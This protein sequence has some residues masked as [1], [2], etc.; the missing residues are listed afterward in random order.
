[1]NTEW[2]GGSIARRAGAA[3][4]SFRHKLLDTQISGQYR[5]VVSGMQQESGSTFSG[6]K[7][8]FTDPGVDADSG[9]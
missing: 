2:A 9:D 8:R 7:R 6:W 1:L 4:K 3:K 5:Q